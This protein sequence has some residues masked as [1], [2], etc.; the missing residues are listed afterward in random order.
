MKLHNLLIAATATMLFTVAA[1]ADTTINITGSSAFR[2]AVVKAIK[3]T[4]TSTTKIAYTGS[5]D[6]S[7]NQ[8]LFVGSF[9]GISGVTTIRTSWNGSVE[10]VRALAGLD[11]VSFIPA[12]AAAGA[13]AGSLEVGTPN[14]AFSDV[15][16]DSTGVSDP[17]YDDTYVGVVSFTWVANEGA[18]FTN[19]T[20]QVA[21]QILSSGV[22]QKNFF[23]GNSADSTS[24]V[25]LTG[26]YNGSGT[27][28]SALA[29][30]G[31]PLFANIRQ[32]V[33]E[34]SGTNGTITGL[35]LWP[36]LSQ[37]SIS[38]GTNDATS[39]NGG[40]T[41]GSGIRD[42]IGCTM[43]AT[44]NL[45]NS[46][47]TVTSTA[48]GST[49]S[50]VSYL[51]IGDQ[52]HANAAGS[53]ALNYNGVP[54]SIANVQNGFYTFWGVQHLLTTFSELSS[55]QA[56]FYNAVTG[57]AATSGRGAISKALTAL[58]ASAPGVTL[59]S[60][61]VTRATTDGSLVG[62]GTYDEPSAL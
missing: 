46:A 9:P 10:G 53:V 31:Y 42:V 62:P 23:T 61:K 33:V 32:Y 17:V 41:S 24:K 54:Y 43:A 60:M 4:L 30:A 22:I 59:E 15:F 11:P 58:G 27:R 1:H 56:T 7:G 20:T 35:R 18:S 6:N 34:T 50:V 37:G 13:Y 3:D 19:I 49:L 38:G 16:Q 14:F 5:A 36:N 44:V 29:E 45:K 55:D 28:A 39:G 12:T 26:R 8:Q 2:S 52:T 57:F 21:N 25:Y 51:G 47:G 48:S 40:Y